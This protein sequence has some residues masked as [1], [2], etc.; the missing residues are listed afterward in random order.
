MPWSRLSWRGRALSPCSISR[1]NLAG[2]WK[3]Y[4]L[5]GLSLVTVAA[6]LV[7]GTK[8]R[9]HSGFGRPSSQIAPST[10]RIAIA[11]IEKSVLAAGTIQPFKMVSVGAQASGQ[12]RSLKVKLGDVVREGDLVAEID[13]ITEENALKN[14]RAAL[15][16]FRAQRKVRMA[17][18][19]QAQLAFERE[20]TMVEQDASSRADYEAAEANLL[21]ARAEFEALDAQLVQGQTAL[22]IAKASLGYTKIKSPLSGTIIAIVT[23]EGQTVNANQ[24]APTIVKI[25]QLDTVTVSAEISEADIVHVRP[26]QRVYFTILGSPEKRYESQLRNIAPAPQ[27]WEAESSSGAGTAG[28]GSTSTAVYYNGLFDVPNPGGELRAGMTAQVFIVLAEVKHALAMP[29]AAI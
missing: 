18:L 21:T 9:F 5:L 13:A 1:R 23:K 7:I 15:D 2:L 3:T 27:S 26:G 10:I 6:I 29:A 4:L 8:T 14:A 24:T 28:P 16:G 12:I 25:A 22:D 19:K 11:D 17:L 20:K